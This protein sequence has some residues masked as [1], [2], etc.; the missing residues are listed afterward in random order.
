[1]EKPALNLRPVQDL[2]DKHT[3]HKYPY[4]QEFKG[5]NL[6]IYP[7]VFNPAYTTVS[8]LL[9][10]NLPTEPGKKVLDMFCGSGALGL[11][12]ASSADK[13]V[14]IDISPLAVRCAT[15]NASSNGFSD[16]TDFRCG[17][18]W[19]AVEENEVF[20]LII[21]NPPLLPITPATLLEKAVADSPKMDVLTRFIEGCRDHLSTEGNVLMAF[22]DASKVIFEDPLNHVKNLSSKA[23][24]TMSIKAEKDVG[25][26]IYRVL[27]LKRRN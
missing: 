11:T 17:D 1:M 16:R 15:E 14:G 6:L 13:V 25:Y 21:A 5:I 2:L 4:K 23:G 10:E 7:E 20:D 19:T 12:I 8:G 27:E 22:S 18:I 26:E 24:L 9:Q 3:R